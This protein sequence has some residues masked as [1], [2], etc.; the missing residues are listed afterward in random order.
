[1]ADAAYAELVEAA[2]SLVAR[3]RS[4][5]AAVPGAL[6]VPGVAVLERVVAG[7]R[8]LEE[9][10]HVRDMLGHACDM[11]DASILARQD[12]IKACGRWSG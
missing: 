10:V 9:L 5:Q 1:M 8:P 4:Y 6:D 12:A 7:E 2:V 11:L 3:V